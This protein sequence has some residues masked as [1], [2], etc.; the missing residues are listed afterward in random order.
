MGIKARWK[1]PRHSK[2]SPVPT[3]PGWEPC[4]LQPRAML[5]L[6]TLA[7]LGTPSC[8][9]GTLYGYGGGKYFNISADNENEITA[10]RFCIGL[11]GLFKSVQ[12]RVGSSWSE[13]QGATGG[14]CQEFILWPGEH[15]I[16]AYGTYRLF[17]R[18]LVLY[19][20]LGRVATF[21]S[22]NGQSFFAYPDKKGQ[23]LTG[24]SGQHK[25]LGISGLI[26]EWNFH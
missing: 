13:R 23:V 25:P 21:G 2:D 9:A 24:V 18:S 7:V 15:I 22:E 20:N 8:W 6:L 3:S 10:I 16:S 17:L 5:L 11:G 1:A 4:D 12:L 19:T 14:K 26:F